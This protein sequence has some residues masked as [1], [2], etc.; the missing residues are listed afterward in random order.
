MIT[1]NDNKLEYVQMIIDKSIEISIKN[2]RYFNSNNIGTNI[3]IDIKSSMVRTVVKSYKYLYIGKLSKELTSDSDISKFISENIWSN[4]Y[5][6]HQKPNDFVELFLE[7]KV[8]IDMF[9]YNTVFESIMGYIPELKDNKFNHRRVSYDD[10]YS[11]IFKLIPEYFDIVDRAKIF[12]SAKMKKVNSVDVYS[13][14]LSINSIIA[15]CY[16]SSG[17]FIGNEIN[18]FTEQELSDL[19]KLIKFMKTDHYIDQKYILMYQVKLNEALI[20]K[21]KRPN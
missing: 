15:D 21:E 5:K 7:Y 14:D 3:S 2:K 8:M 13:I 20:R 11:R 10:S 9:D 19:D 17:P 4:F 12:S 16:Y 1:L 18:D 6:A